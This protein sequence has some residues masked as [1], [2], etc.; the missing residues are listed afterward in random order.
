MDI[1]VLSILGHSCLK[2]TAQEHIASLYAP[3]KNRTWTT[4]FEDWCDIRFTTGALYEGLYQNL[5]KK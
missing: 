5:A 4:S 2:A 1:F 3:A